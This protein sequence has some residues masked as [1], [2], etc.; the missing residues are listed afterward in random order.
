MPLFTFKFTVFPPH[1]CHPSPHPPSH[2]HSTVPTMPHCH[3]PTLHHRA[4]T[5]ASSV[6]CYLTV[7]V[8]STV[9]ALL[10]FHWLLLV[11]LHPM[12]LLSYTTLHCTLPI[13]NP[14]M[15]QLIMHLQPDHF[16][17]CGISLISNACRDVS[18]AKTCN[19]SYTHSFQFTACDGTVIY[20]A[21]LHDYTIDACYI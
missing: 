9:R 13:P 19:L 21:D 11:R 12:R 16:D 4:Y 14:D 18:Q 8:Y 7:R 20:I 15:L 3:P 17:E 5:V 10:I 6:M 2:F 1:T